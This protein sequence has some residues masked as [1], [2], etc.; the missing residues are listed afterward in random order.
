VLPISTKKVY[1]C[2][3]LDGE[4]LGPQCSGVYEDLDFLKQEC[5]EE[6]DSDILWS[7][8]CE[9]LDESLMK[10]GIDSN[11]SGS[12]WDI[13]GIDKKTGEVVIGIMED[14][15]RKQHS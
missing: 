7:D 13:E 6:S 11:Y 5:R 4:S 9:D 8:E 14:H 15:L 10:W 2:N 1:I 12:N 3:T